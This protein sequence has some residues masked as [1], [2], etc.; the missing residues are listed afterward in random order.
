LDLARNA[1]VKSKVPVGV[2][3]LEM[4]S[5]QLVNRLISSEAE[6]DSDK[7]KKGKVETDQLFCVSMNVDVANEFAHFEKT[8]N[9][10]I[11]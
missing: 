4:S 7:I 11:S 8:V 9:A 6:L 3:S 1:A 5:I 10:T 2:F